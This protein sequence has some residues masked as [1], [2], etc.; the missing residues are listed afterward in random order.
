MKNFIFLLA[1]IFFFCSS[2]KK[3]DAGSNP[4]AEK[5]FESNILTKDFVVSFAKDSTTD[6]TSQYAG[7][8]FVLLKE[9]LLHG[10]LTATKGTTTYTGSWSC[11]SDYSKLTITLPNTPSE[12]QFLSR[13][14]RF[15][16]K[17]LPTLKLAPWFTRDPIE[18]HMLRK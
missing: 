15:T 17:K 18:L 4:L 6:L 14:W 3:G 16:S 2:C 9:D 5:Y 12:F 1:A 8:T 7:Y 11:N 13:A 10:P